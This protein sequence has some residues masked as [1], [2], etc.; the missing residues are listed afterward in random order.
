MVFYM[1]NPDV[2]I[3]TVTCLLFFRFCVST[4]SVCTWNNRHYLYVFLNWCWHF[5]VQRGTHAVCLHLLRGS[6]ISVPLL[7]CLFQHRQ[8]M[9]FILYKCHSFILGSLIAAYDKCIIMNIYSVY[10][11]VEKTLSFYLILLSF[12]LYFGF[13]YMFFHFSLFHFGFF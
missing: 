11:G 9:L 12:F 5:I 1:Y 8:I 4:H 3:W 6:R 10:A 2:N 7:V 13:I